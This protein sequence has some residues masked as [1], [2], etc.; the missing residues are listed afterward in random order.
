MKTLRL[1]KR[2]FYQRIGGLD[3]Y[4]NKNVLDLGC[5]DGEDAY[6]IS[7]FA[8][9]VTGVDI[10]YNPNWEKRKSKKLNFIISKAEK[11]PF[12]ANM[13]D[14]LFLK[15][16]IHHVEDI[17]KTLKEI[18]RVTSKDAL[19]ILIEGNRYNPIFYIHMTK[20]LGHE[21]LTQEDFKK[22]VLKYFP[23]SKF[24]H[25]EAH[26]IPFLSVRVFKVFIRLER[27][28]AKVPLIS[29]LLSYNAAIIN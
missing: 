29:K 17:E 6:E 3:Q 22:L 9:N 15:D 23:D 1:F 2:D 18:K 5:G 20:I 24:I 25:F 4:R 28:L 10:T 13:F 27:I 14:G 19:I 16:V 21:H 26:F 7:K 11:L 8:K 12:K